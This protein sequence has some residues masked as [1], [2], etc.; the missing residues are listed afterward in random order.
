MRG[1]TLVVRSRGQ[2]DIHF[3]FGFGRHHD[4]VTIHISAA[5]LKS[6][7]M[8]GSGDV[9]LNRLHGDAFSIAVSA[10][11]DLR[12]N[13]EVRQLGVSSSGSGDLDLRGL[14]AANVDIDMH[15]S[16]DVRLA[17]PTGTLSAQVSGSGDLSA[18]GLRTSRV[19]VTQRAS[20]DVHLSGS[21]RELRVETSGSGD[22]DGCGLKVDSA[23]SVQ[24]ASGSAC[25]AGA[26]AFDA[27]VAGSG[28]LSVRGLQGQTARLR[29]HGPGNVDLDGTVGLLTAELSGS[30]DLDAHGLSAGHAEV[31]VH[32]PGSARVRVLDQGA[33]GRLLMVDRSGTRMVQ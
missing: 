28:D 20:G 24:S 33:Q 31:Q 9:D 1:D 23:N 19:E 5:N 6:L 30:G 13:G 8:S 15:A 32:G 25:F 10:S 21:S 3:Y 22:F 12:A 27:D 29:M 26:R 7:R 17:G 16:G 11:G 14:Q 18:D 2:H 4:E